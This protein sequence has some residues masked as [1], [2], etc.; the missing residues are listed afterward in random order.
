MTAPKQTCP[1]SKFRSPIWRFVDDVGIYFDESAGL[2]QF[3]SASRLGYGDGDANRKRMEEIRA[4]YTR[5]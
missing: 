3:R 1:R 5:G 4:A 2:I